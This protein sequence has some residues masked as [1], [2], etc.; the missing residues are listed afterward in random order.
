MCT[1]NFTL[2]I[3]FGS[4]FHGRRN[5]GIFSA[6]CWVYVQSEYSTSDAERRHFISRFTGSAGTAVV[7]T[8]AA[9]LWTDGRYFLQVLASSFAVV[10]D[11]TTH[12]ML[13]MWVRIVAGT[14]LTAAWAGMD[15]HEGWH[16]WLSRD[17]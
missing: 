15:A 2:T 5:P 13:C 10:G 7:T 6:L 12:R 14:G 8:D 3:S 16:H 11:V 1:R 9:L 4:N 17:P